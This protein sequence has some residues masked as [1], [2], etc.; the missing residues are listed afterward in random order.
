MFKRNEAARKR[1]KYSSVRPAKKLQGEPG[2]KSTDMCESGRNG[3][4][5]TEREELCLTFGQC[6]RGAVAFGSWL[7]RVHNAYCRATH[8]TSV[9]ANA[10]TQRDAAGSSFRISVSP[11]RHSPCFF[12]HPC[13]TTANTRNPWFLARAIISNGSRRVE[14][15]VDSSFL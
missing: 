6:R 5:V 14:N 9:C 13:F 3:Q 7:W 15:E 8:C 2:R 10:S 1:L 11:K 12:L 4:G